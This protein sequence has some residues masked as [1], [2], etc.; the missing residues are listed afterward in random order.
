MEDLWKL[1]RSYLIEA[2][3]LLQKTDGRPMPEDKRKR[4]LSRLQDLEGRIIPT[5]LEKLYRTPTTP[6]GF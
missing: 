5:L 4:C 1:Y 3:R 6:I 2:N